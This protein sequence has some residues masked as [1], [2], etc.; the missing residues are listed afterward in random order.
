MAADHGVLSIFFRFVSCEAPPVCSHLPSWRTVLTGFVCLLALVLCYCSCF[1]AQVVVF[2]AVVQ[3]SVGAHFDYDDD[4]DAFLFIF[5]RIINHVQTNI[6]K[7]ASFAF[8]P[9][10]VWTRIMLVFFLLPWVT[11]CRALFSAVLPLADA[12]KWKWCKVCFLFSAALLRLRV[13]CID[14]CFRRRIV[15]LSEF[16]AAASFKIKGTIKIV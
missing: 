6:P 11:S 2:S 12:K 16:A 13:H 3:P 7:L 4:D 10:V 14:F 1:H 8:I 9:L 5:L 15:L